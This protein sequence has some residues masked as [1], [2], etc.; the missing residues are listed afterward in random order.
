MKH[1]VKYYTVN[2]GDCAL[3]LWEYKLPLYIVLK[4]PNSYPLILHNS[5]ENSAQQLETSI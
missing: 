2:D 4:M 3:W 1:Q 5:E